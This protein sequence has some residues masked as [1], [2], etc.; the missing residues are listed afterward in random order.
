MMCHPT[1]TVGAKGA[2]TVAVR[3]SGQEKTHLTVVLACCAD[4]TKLPP[5]IIFTRKMFLKETIP[6][7]VNVR[8]HEKGWMNEEGMKIWFN[9]V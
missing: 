4:G 5:V 7:G 6:S 3:T 1:E 2:E 9:K 8:V